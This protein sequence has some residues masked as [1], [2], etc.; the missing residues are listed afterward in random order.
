MSNPSQDIKNLITK[1]KKL[2]KDAADELLDLGNEAAE[3]IRKRTRLGYSV[4]EQGGRKTKLDSLSEGYKANRKRSR[5]TGPT[6]PNKSNLTNTGDMLDD[7]EAKKSSE[8]SVTITFSSKKSKDK[9]I[10]VSKKRP[11]NYLS[12]AEKKQLIQSLQKR[13]NKKNK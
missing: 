1:V 12:K 10:W 2:R 11:F 4:A 5:P 3:L 7:L 8:S 9:A 6:T 13:I